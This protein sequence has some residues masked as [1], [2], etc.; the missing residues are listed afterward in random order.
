MIYTCSKMFLVGVVI[1]CDLSFAGTLLCK[2]WKTKNR[3]SL[4]KNMKASGAKELRGRYAIPLML[5]GDGRYTVYLTWKLVHVS[6]GILWLS[7][8][9]MKSLL[10]Y[11]FIRWADKWG[12]STNTLI[13]TYI[14]DWD[15]RHLSASIM[16]DLITSFKHASKQIGNSFF[17]QEVFEECE[18]LIIGIG[19]KE[20]LTEFQIKNL[21]D[22]TAA[23]SS[24]IAF[25]TTLQI[26][27]AH[28]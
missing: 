27:R 22:I 25:G 23:Q 12:L 26:G 3:M 4:L 9:E 28:V 13:S 15:T 14:K 21:F 18:V 19:L 17:P 6:S 7:T 5:V 8:E 16:A 2:P 10:N 11:F 24:W 20:K 1:G